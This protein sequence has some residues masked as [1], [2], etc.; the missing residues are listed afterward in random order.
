[1]A[2][3]RTKILS[4]DRVIQVCDWI[5]HRYP[6]I[7][8]YAIIGDDDY[9]LIMRKLSERLASHDIIAVLPQK[10]NTYAN[11]EGDGMRHV[12]LELGCIDMA[13]LEHTDGVIVVNPDKDISDFVQDQI[14][15][16]RYKDIGDGTKQVHWP[17]KCVLYLDQIVKDIKGFKY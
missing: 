8:L 12:S 16:V 6:E 1:M 13:T 5:Q 7:R 11:L 4:N 3:R 14:K 15:Y 17:M 10:F 2:K 9:H